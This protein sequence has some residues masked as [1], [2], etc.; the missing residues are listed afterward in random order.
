MR[1]ENWDSRTADVVMLNDVEIEN[2][3]K[4]VG[5]KLGAKDGGKLEDGSAVGCL[6]SEGEE[7]GADIGTAV[8]TVGFAYENEYTFVALVAPKVNGNS[9]VRV[10]TTVG[11]EDVIFTYEY[12]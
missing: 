8:G 11:S 4:V 5:C 6:V 3:S 10:G 7:V 12:E 9:F 2:V 1:D